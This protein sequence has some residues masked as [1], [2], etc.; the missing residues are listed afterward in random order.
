MDPGIPGVRAVVPGS[1]LPRNTL[2]PRGGAATHRIANPVYTSSNLVEASLGRL[3]KGSPLN[4]KVGRVD[5]CAG[6]ETQCTFIAY[7]GFESLTFRCTSVGIA[8]KA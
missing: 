2:W 4:W 8:S 5:E 3:P 7:P 1:M 6:F